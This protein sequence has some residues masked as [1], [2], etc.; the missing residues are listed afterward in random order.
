MENR[1]YK[2]DPT[3][4]DKAELLRR[5]PPWH[6]IPDENQGLVR[7]SSAAFADDKDG[8]MSVTLAEELTKEGRSLDSVL[9]GHGDFALASITA[10]LVRECEQGIVRAPTDDEPAHALVFGKKTK[11]IQRKLVKGARWIIPPSGS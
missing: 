1:G 5:I 2:D 11:S 10:G 4:P 8:P 7:P 9:V 3:I 6:F